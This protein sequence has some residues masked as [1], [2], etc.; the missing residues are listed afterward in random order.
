MASEI[1]EIDETTSLEERHYWCTVL[2][3]QGW[4]DE[5]ALEATGL[6]VRFDAASGTKECYIKNLNP[7]RPPQGIQLS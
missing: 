3:E 7:N 1:S 4:D 5:V 6:G 2:L